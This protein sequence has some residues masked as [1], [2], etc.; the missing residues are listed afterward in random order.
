MKGENMRKKIIRNAAKCLKCNDIIESKHV[1]DFVT[2]R[3]GAISVDGGHD[4]LK[5]SFTPGSKYED[6]TIMEDP[7][8]IRNPEEK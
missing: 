2:C 3:C 7:D 4:Y 5:R 1:H 8:I 6:L